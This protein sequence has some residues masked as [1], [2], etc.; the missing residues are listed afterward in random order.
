MLRQEIVTRYIGQNIVVASKD[1][2]ED[3]NK[4]RHRSQIWGATGCL[5]WVVSRRS[6]LYHLNGRYR[7]QRKI[8]FIR[9]MIGELFY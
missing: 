2:L 7:V 9:L 3:S 6:E 1:V 8:L 4:I 5:L